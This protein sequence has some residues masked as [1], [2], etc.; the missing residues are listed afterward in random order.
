MSVSILT[1]F[2]ILFVV[3]NIF[4]ME[5]EDLSVIDHKSNKEL[6]E[7]VDY[8]WGQLQIITEKPHPYSSHFNVEVHDHIL[9]EVSKIIENENI[10]ISR[11]ITI[12]SDPRRLLSSN[13]TSSIQSLKKPSLFHM[14]LITSL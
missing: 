14:S 8:S 1:L 3:F 5:R 13:R 9:S 10:D 6:K 12:D 11:E 4:S 2:S 7:L